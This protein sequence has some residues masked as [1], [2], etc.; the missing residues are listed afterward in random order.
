[1]L[2][3]VKIMDDYG[4]RLIA[5]LVVNI[6]AGV[7]QYIAT[8]YTTITRPGSFGLYFIILPAGFHSFGWDLGTWPVGLMVLIGILV[9]LNSSRIRTPLKE[10]L[11]VEHKSV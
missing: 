9:L 6:S 2:K 4:Y 10:Q 7:I 3:R 5:I 11:E 8:K 1:M